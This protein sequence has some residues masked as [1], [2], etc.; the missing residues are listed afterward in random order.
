MWN[1]PSPNNAHKFS[2][3]KNNQI[4]SK[5]KMIYRQKKL[6]KISKKAKREIA[7]RV[8]EAVKEFGALSKLSM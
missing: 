4:L 1:D 5:Y 8:G 6:R 7:M 2:Y 3:P